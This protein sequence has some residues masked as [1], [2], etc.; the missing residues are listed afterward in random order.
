MNRREAVRAKCILVLER[1]GFID[2]A[3]SRVEVFSAF[4][5]V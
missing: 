2:A 4:D 3:N 5:T 1:I